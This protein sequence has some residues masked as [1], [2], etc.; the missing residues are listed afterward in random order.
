MALPLFVEKIDDVD[1]N[2]RSLYSEKDGKFYLDAE[3]LEDLHSEVNKSKSFVKRANDEAKAERLKRRAYEAIGKSPEEIQAILEEYGSLQELKEKHEMTEAEKKGQW[4]QL[5]AQMNEKH[6]EQLKAK[7]ALILA[8]QEKNNRLLSSIQQHLVN[9]SA[10]AAIAQHKGIPQLL[11]PFVARHIKCSRDEETG[12]FQLSV[13]DDKG[14]PKVNGKG[15]PLTI[16]EFVSEMRADATFGRAFEGTGASG[17][18]PRPPGGAPQ[19]HPSITKKSDLKNEKDR[20]AYV[21]K[22]GLA[23]YAALPN[24]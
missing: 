19:G 4:D 18:G 12:E 7:D 14:E 17:G 22:Y 1:E 10:T 8:E 5:R 2:L 13:V 6:A 20:A 11:L 21:D 23:T 9:S 3:G 16:E 15:E 24:A